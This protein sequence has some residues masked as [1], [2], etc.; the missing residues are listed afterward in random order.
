M[1]IRIRIWVLDFSQLRPQIKEKVMNCETRGGLFHC[2]M[3]QI[4]LWFC[5]FC[6]AKT[7]L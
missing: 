5:D 4:V 6:F 3:V 1:K 2:F 7:F